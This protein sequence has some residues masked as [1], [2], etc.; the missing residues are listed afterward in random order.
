MEGLDKVVRHIG[1][2]NGGL[3]PLPVRQ[4][5][6]K[7]CDGTCNRD[8]HKQ[9]F[10]DGTEKIVG[11]KCEEVK[12]LQSIQKRAKHRG[13]IKQSDIPYSRRQSAFDKF[14]ADDSLK[15][16]AKKAAM[17]YAQNFSRNFN[18]KKQ[19]N[20]VADYADNHDMTIDEANEALG[21][22]AA[23]TV[24]VGD[25]ERH[26]DDILT[27]LILMGTPGTGKTMLASGIFHAVADEGFNCF[28][29]ESTKFTETL[30]EGFDNPDKRYRL[31]KFIEEADLLIVDDIGTAFNSPW[32][33]DQFKIL[34][35]MRQDKFTIYTTNLTEKEFLDEISLHRVYSRMNQNAYLIEMNFEDKRL[36]R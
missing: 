11:C 6:V 35:D 14:H 16:N 27:N 19:F 25:S 3:P 23:E 18:A 29:I 13:F 1:R 31:M 8:I 26:V 24:K 5:F 22:N 28:F 21:M 34:A 9:T 33:V 12:R 36:K 17:V 32:A 30:K 2:Q 20:I 10:E 7:R 4:E 15:S